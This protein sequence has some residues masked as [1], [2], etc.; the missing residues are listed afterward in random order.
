MREAY[1]KRMKISEIISIRT[2]L[3]KSLEMP[4]CEYT[5]HLAYL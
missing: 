2:K 4:A 5:V 3:Q 1:E